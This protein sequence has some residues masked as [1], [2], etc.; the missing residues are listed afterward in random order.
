MTPANT[1]GTPSDKQL[2]KC[3]RLEEQ[4]TGSSGYPTTLTRMSNRTLQAPLY[5]TCILVDE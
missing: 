1:G 5:Y 4:K 3:A 2:P